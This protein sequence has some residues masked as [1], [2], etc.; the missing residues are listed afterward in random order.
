M[1]LFI[2]H[3]ERLLL[4]FF[5]FQIYKH[6]HT[7]LQILG[8]CVCV[9]WAM[10]QISSPWRCR[11][12]RHCGC[13]CCR[14]FSLVVFSF[15]WKFSFTETE[16]LIALRLSNIDVHTGDWAYKIQIQMKQQQQHFIIMTIIKHFALNVLYYI[17]MLALVWKCHTKC[18]HFA[19]F[20]ARA[21]TKMKTLIGCL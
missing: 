20:C 14:F 18:A 5:F 8:D 12:L 3:Y 19:H 6:T 17:I 4:K 21:K 10:N 1:R 13:C 15:V 9:P 11:R 7:H 2:F 16:I